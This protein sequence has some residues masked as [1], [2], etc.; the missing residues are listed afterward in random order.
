M[1]LCF[2][3]LEPI[4]LTSGNDDS[5]SYSFDIRRMD[6][7]KVIHKGHIGAVIDLDYASSGR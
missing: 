7:A 5:N 4:N 1:S 3:P 2:N 6:R